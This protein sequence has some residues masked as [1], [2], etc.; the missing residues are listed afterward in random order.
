M[1][2]ASSVGDKGSAA[3]A[4]YTRDDAERTIV[5]PIAVQEPFLRLIGG[6]SPHLIKIKLEERE[7]QD[8]RRRLT[9]QPRVLDMI[10]KYHVCNTNNF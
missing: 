9:T 6:T 1:R 3:V 7:K 2:V 10:P 5:T 4:V 8:S